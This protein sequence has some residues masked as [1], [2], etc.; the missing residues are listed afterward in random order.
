MESSWNI[1]T[2]LP[3]HPAGSP[4]CRQLTVPFLVLSAEGITRPADSDRRGRRAEMPKQGRW[5]SAQL[6]PGK[7]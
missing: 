5:A 6:L 3:S 4:N 7:P 2:Y 1:Q